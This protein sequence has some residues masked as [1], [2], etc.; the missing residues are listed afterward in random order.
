MGVISI[1]RAAERS[2]LPGSLLL[3]LA[4]L[5]GPPPSA[6]QS[7]RPAL[8]PPPPFRAPPFRAAPAT[9]ALGRGV[10]VSGHLTT[11]AA[12]TISLSYGPDWRGQPT[13]TVTAPVSAAGDFRLTLPP[14]PAPTEA[15]LGYGSEVATLYL[16]PG[17]ALRLTFAPGRLDQTL[18]FVGGGANAN[19]YLAQSYLLASQDDEARRTPDARAATLSAAALRRAADAYRQQRQ[20]ALA[21]YAQAHPLPAA[22][23]RQQRQALDYEW[24]SSLLGYAARQSA[25]RR[26][27]GYATL[28]VDYYDFISDLQLGRRDSALTQ[29]AFQSVLMSYGFAQLNDAEGN[30][31]AG[32]DAGARLYQ[33]ATAALGAGR[34]RDVAVGQYLLGKVESEHADI[35]PLL[36]A[37]R[38]HNRD[39]TIARALRAAVRAHLGLASGQPAPDFTLPD[40]TGKLVALSSFR[41]QV[42]Y[43]DFW[44]SWC[45]PCLAEMPASRALRQQFAGRGVVFLYVSLDSRAADWQRALAAQPPAGPSA[46]A[47]AAQLHDGAA[48]AGAAA[49]AYGVRALPSYWLIGRD[50]R[51]LA[52]PAP[53]PSAGPAAA[54]ALEQALK[55]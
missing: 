50:G 49:R 53:R 32:P 47:N 16:T 40:N 30:L 25:E 2:T 28:P 19:N 26:Q 5:G 33:Q 45:A 51:L 21:A 27:Q 54:A 52:N 42:V 17:D 9:G 48:F 55:P 39:S 3:A 14:L 29:S 13:Q 11:V 1:G 7:R 12:A 37:F 18:A 24:A 23:V 36:P 34:V 22:F 8:P 15:R 35:R 31:P 44:A 4:L 41:G 38:A 6:A 20:A 10:V 43:L 46:D